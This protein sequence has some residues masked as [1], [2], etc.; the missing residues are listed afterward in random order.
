MPVKSPIGIEAIKP[1]NVSDD[2]VST[3]ILD[4][5]IY[6]IFTSQKI[7]MDWKY[8]EKIRRRQ[9]RHITS[10]SRFGHSPSVR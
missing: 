1:I 7:E 3:P 9:L 5:H 10:Y 8:W 4:I 6:R 2:K